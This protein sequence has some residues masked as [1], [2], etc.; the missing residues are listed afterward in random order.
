LPLIVDDYHWHTLAT[1]NYPL[2]LAGVSFADKLTG[3]PFH[4]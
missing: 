2:S 1:S 3:C 4:P